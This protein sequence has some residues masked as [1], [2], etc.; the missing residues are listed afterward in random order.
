MIAEHAKAKKREREAALAAE[1]ERKK[2]A[3]EAQE[4]AKAAAASE[5]SKDSG[6]G[7]TAPADIREDGRE[8]VIDLTEDDDDDNKTLSGNAAKRTRE[9]NN[10]EGGENSADGIEGES[11]KPKLEAQSQQLGDT[12]TLSEKAEGAGDEASAPTTTDET[13]RQP[14]DL[15]TMGMPDLSGV[16]FSAFMNMSGGGGGDTT[17]SLSAP[18]FGAFNLDGSAGNGAQIT[19]GGGNGDSLDADNLMAAMSDAN[20]S[21]QDDFS[22]INLEGMDFPTA[23]QGVDWSSLL[24]GFHGGGGG[25]DEAGQSKS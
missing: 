4:A 18:D 25:A 17:A 2:A 21:G 3:A 15:S 8:G 22:G 16:D 13:M 24:Q 11:K 12:S 14:L 1:E 5:P 7:G 6:S 20:F 10:A 9:G 19:G 23:L